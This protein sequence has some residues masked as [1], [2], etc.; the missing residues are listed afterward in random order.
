LERDGRGHNE[1]GHGLITER[2][3]QAASAEAGLLSIHK[4]VLE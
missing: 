1:D 3:E 2:K 4:R